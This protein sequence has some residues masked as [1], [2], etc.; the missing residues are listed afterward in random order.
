MLKV[1]I[2]GQR[3]MS[4]LFVNGYTILNG[5]SMIWYIQKKLSTIQKDFS[6]NKIW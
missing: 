3:V 1:V 4:V 6:H 2:I 5:I